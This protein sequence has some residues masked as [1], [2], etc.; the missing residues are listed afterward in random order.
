M[1]DARPVA[2]ELPWT[3]GIEIEMLFVL[4]EKQKVSADPE[5][6]YILPDHFI[7]RVYTRLD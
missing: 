6:H 7:E 5:Y 3:F 2:Q 4:H 1:A